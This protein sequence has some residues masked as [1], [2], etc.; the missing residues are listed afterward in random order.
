MRI[1]AIIARCND[2]ELGPACTS[3]RGKDGEGLGEYAIIPSPLSLEHSF[4][5]RISKQTE[6]W[7][8]C[9]ALGQAY[10]TS[11]GISLNYK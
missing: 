4:D 11:Q 2:Q 3:H 5:L 9:C 10:C 8:N 7:Q 1:S 6:P